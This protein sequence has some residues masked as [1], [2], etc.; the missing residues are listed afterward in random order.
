MRTRRQAIR[1]RFTIK[2]AIALFALAAPGVI[3]SAPA[4]AT[5]ADA[6]PAVARCRLNLPM[7]VRPAR[8][9][10]TSDRR[11]ASR[12]GSASC[13]G[14][15]GPW[16]IG[17]QPGWETSEVAVLRV[18]QLH[19]GATRSCAPSVIRGSLFA[20]VPRL[21]RHE[22]RVTF[23]GSFRLHRVGSKF[24]LTGLGHLVPTRESPLRARLSFTG[25]ASFTPLGKQR[26]QASRLSGDL[27]IQ[28]VVHAD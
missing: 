17:G 24:D 19:R 5:P 23:S 26:C 21:A 11:F 10:H 25:S 4:T 3:G 16:L 8:P 1:P 22:R 9:G 2:A 28:L 27:T 13:K 20:V 6:M 15:L 12:S 14:A 18:V 7:T